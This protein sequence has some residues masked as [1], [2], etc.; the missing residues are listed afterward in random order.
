MMSSCLKNRKS[1]LKKG[2][3][4]VDLV[5]SITIFAT[6][7]ALIT[8]VSYYLYV[9][10]ALLTATREGARLA[11]VQSNFQN[12]GNTATG[13]AEVQQL[14]KDFALS[15]CGQVLDNTN[16]TITVTPPNPAGVFGNRT[17]TVKL[18][19]NIPNPIP[20]ASGVQS[21]TGQTYSNLQAL[22]MVSQ[23]SMRFEE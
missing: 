3:A 20:I 10:H 14:V 1:H 2:Q 5:A 22:P 8:T 18:I 19:Y 12:G 13:I 17:V 16:S 23:T 6:M 11:S 15:T 4:V 9:W 21:L 7:T